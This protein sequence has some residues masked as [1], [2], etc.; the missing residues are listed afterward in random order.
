[1]GS[2]TLRV[3]LVRRFPASNR[4][5]S[6]ARARVGGPDPWGYVPPPLPLKCVGAPLHGLVHK[7]H[8]SPK[9]RATSASAAVYVLR[10]VLGCALNDRPRFYGEPPIH[11]LLAP[12]HI[13][14]A[15]CYFKAAAATG[16]NRD[17]PTSCGSI[18]SRSAAGASQPLGATSAQRTLTARC[19]L[20]RACVDDFAAVTASAVRFSGVWY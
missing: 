3:G 17:K 6:C 12:G 10:P 13:G 8:S 11:D 15:L 18:G 9:T 5:R 20:R 7:K 14:R 16:G 19:E 1:V 2:P 4:Q